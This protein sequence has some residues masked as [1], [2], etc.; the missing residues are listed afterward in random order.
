MRRYSSGHGWLP[1]EDGTLRKHFAELSRGHRPS[2]GIP[3][4]FITAQRF[5]ALYLFNRFRPLGNGY[6]PQV[7][8]KAHDCLR[9]EAGALIYNNVIYQ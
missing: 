5:E 7:L 8:G 3:L 4:D 6:I 2:K 1:R 9:F